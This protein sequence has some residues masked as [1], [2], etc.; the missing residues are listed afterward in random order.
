MTT[1]DVSYGPHCWICKGL[2]PIIAIRRITQEIIQGN[3]LEP[4]A[5]E[6]TTKAPI[7]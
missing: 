5:N 6:R 7:K 4:R 1:N 3:D 2:D